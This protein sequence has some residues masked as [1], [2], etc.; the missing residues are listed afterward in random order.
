MKIRIKD[1]REIEKTFTRTEGGFGKA[2]SVRF[3]SAMKK[4]CGKII[5]ADSNCYMGPGSSLTAEGYWWDKEW[6]TV[7]GFEQGD[8]VR[9]I[10]I[11]S[12]SGSHELMI[13]FKYQI[14]KVVDGNFVL[15]L[16]HKIHIS[17]IEMA[18][19]GED[20]T[21]FVIDAAKKVLE[22]NG[23]EIKKLDM[24]A[25]NKV[26]GDDIDKFSMEAFGN[27][28]VMIGDG[29]APTEE[30]R[31]RCLYVARSVIVVTEPCDGG[32]IIK[33]LNKQAWRITQE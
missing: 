16:G 33:F 27:H 25:M 3:T 2:R 30:L 7:V 21:S 1:Y 8:I 20:P 6:Y 28:V 11:G 4:H 32:T 17:D 31:H 15:I 10:G 14:N 19:K 24:N 22:A 12:L 13:G 9:L 5:E 23:F 18:E 29:F 26:V